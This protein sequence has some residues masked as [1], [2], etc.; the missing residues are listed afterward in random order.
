MEEPLRWRSQHPWTTNSPGRS[1]IYRG[2]RAGAGRDG[3]RAERVV[4]PA[5]FPARA[6]QPRVSL[7]AGDG[8][9]ETWRYGGTSHCRYGVGDPSHRGGLPEIEPGLERDRGAAAK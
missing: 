7:A 2:R 8:A 3:P 9:I 5:S 6:D 1:A 4:C